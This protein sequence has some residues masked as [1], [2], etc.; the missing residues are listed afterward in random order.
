[1]SLF[2]L[3]TTSDLDASKSNNMRRVVFYQYPNGKFPLMGLLSMADDAE[4]WDKQT[5]GWHEDRFVLPRADTTS[6]N[7]A[8]PFTDLTGASGAV[9]TDL[10]A[11]GWSAAVGAAIR[12]KVKSAVQYRQ[13]DVIWIKDLPAA[14]GAVLQINAVV[15]AVWAVNNTIDVHLIVAVTN[16]LNDTTCNNLSVDM[17]GSAAVEGGFSKLGGYQFPIDPYN[18]T[19]TYRTVVGPFTRA[20]LKMGLKFDDEGVY[21]TAAKQAHIRHMI[22][23][24]FNSY[25]GILGK[26]TVTDADDNVAKTELTSGGI[27]QFLRYWEQGTTGAGSIVDYRP[28]EGDVSASDW[29]T[30]DRKR[31]ISLNGAAVSKTQFDRLIY[32][33]FLRNG[34]V[35]FEKIV[36]C[37][38]GFLGSFNRFAEANSIKTVQINSKETTYGMTLTVWHTIWGDLYFKTHPLFTENPRFTNSAF[39]LDIGSIKYH[40]LTDSDTELLNNRQARDYD[41]RKDEWLTEY[42]LEIQF[43]E[44]HMFIDNLGGITV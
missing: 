6:A 11:G 2:G 22:A 13:R 36:V 21:Q 43:P 31:I 42:G 5:S 12:I 4:Q 25:F 15:D 30:E 24:E 16:A 32:M 9:G 28:G 39:I 38:A 20:A 3:V 37:G 40:A 27:L 17:V 26:N 19:Q 14:A 10:T 29:K 23:M 34:D 18:N 44:R 41:G 7:A 33:A 35:G 1:M 8:G